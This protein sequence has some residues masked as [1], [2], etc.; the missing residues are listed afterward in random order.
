M[1]FLESIPF[2]QTMSFLCYRNALTLFQQDFLGI[3]KMF[4]FILN[5]LVIEA[6]LQLYGVKFPIKFN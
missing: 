1:I 3:S 6:D 4:R 2:K 5:A